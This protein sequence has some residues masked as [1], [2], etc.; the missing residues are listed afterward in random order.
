MQI[1][2]F[3]KVLLILLDFISNQLNKDYVF[4]FFKY[5]EYLFLQRVS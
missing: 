3:G 5:Y 4:Y 1:A 2:G